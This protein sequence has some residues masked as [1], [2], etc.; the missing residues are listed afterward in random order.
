M[1]P[2][3]KVVVFGGSGF[4]GSH[5]AD[6][7]SD[8]G[9]DV[10]IYDLRESPHLKDNQKMVVGDVLDEGKVNRTLKGAEY[11]YNFSGIA[12]I[13]EC[14][15][16]PLDMVKHNILGHATILDKSRLND[17]KRVIYASSIYVYGRHGSFYRIGKQTCEQLL[18]EYHAR[19][20]LDYTILRYGSLYGPRFQTWNGVYK[21]IYQ[22]IKERRIDYPGTG[23]EKREYIHVSDAA[24]LSVDILKDEFKN[25]CMVITGNY[26]LSSKELLTMIREMLGEEVEINFTNQRSQHHYNITAHSFVPK[27]GMKLMPNPSIDM[28]E[29]ILNQ[30]EEIYKEIK[31]EDLDFIAQDR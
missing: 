4:L 28:G 25:K 16:K 26:T 21:Y 23:E 18:E 20:K 27:V 13:E 22:A 1:N 14:S 30:I 24:R 3:R 10:T 12:E 8:E 11:V 9:Y 6:A 5:V 7:L 15:N 2:V 19:F 17:I 31:N 29:G